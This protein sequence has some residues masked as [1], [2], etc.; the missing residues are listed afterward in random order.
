MTSLVTMSELSLGGINPRQSTEQLDISGAYKSIAIVG[1]NRSGE[2]TFIS[3]KILHDMFP[4]WYRIFVIPRGIYLKGSRDSGT[5][6]EWLRSQLATYD[7][8]NPMASLLDLIAIHH[9]QQRI[10]ILLQKSFGDYLPRL[11]RPQPAIII[12]DQAEE[13]L[14]VYRCEFLEQFYLLV[15]EAR[16]HNSHRL[17]LII[18][19]EY[20]LKA[21]K[22]LNGG[23]LFDFVQA[24]MVSKDAVMKEYDG[25]FV[26]VFEDCENCS[27]TALDFVT[28]NPPMSAKD[29]HNMTKAIYENTN[30]LLDPITFEEYADF[31]DKSKKIKN[32]PIS[33]DMNVN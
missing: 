2:S 22:L 12:V 8:E 26:Q 3:R 14:R 23:N 30:C 5:A 13:L 31:V 4:W 1:G 6:E 7:K 28:N 15:K 17:V 19:T 20:A 25:T 33:R 24:P 10:R 29:Y 32:Y 27:G 18:N 9:R 21:L 16:D 11:L